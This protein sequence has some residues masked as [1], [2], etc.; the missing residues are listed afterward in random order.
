M[1]AR[2]PWLL[3]RR[4]AQAVTRHLPP[5]NLSNRSERSNLVRVN[6]EETKPERKDMFT[7]NNTQA[8]PATNRCWAH[9]HAVGESE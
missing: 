2:K 8:L 4:A 3:P 9:F 6:N 7:H 1:D 5:E